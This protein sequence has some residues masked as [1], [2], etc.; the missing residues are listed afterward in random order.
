M[1]TQQPTMSPLDIVVLLKIAGLGSQSWN[2]LSLAGELHISQS[3]IS[4]SIARSRYAGL[5][6]PTGKK[7][8]N[9]TLL[10]FLVFGIAVV[11]PQQ[12][13]AI[14][15]GIPTAHSAPPLNQIIQS[16]EPFVWLSGKGTSRGQSI[17]PLY[18]SVVHA[19]QI[20]NALYELLALVDAI[21]VGKVR[22]KEIAI[23]ELK[24]RILNEE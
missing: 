7:I 14:V 5:L 16:E 1:K 13:G 12:P 18:P 15:R 3:E 4:K 19:A 8:R 22:E 9:Q 23:K 6:D 11:F 10:N 24:Y 17:A 20:D 21:R 2:Q